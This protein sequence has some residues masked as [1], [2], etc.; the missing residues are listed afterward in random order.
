MNKENQ[1]TI[2]LIAIGIVLL[3]CIVGVI[4]VNFIFGNNN[5][6]DNDNSN[7]NG[8]NN[9]V[10]KSKGNKAIKK[11]YI[12]DLYGVV[13]LTNSGDLYGI[14]DFDVIDE[15]DKDKV[16]L[17]A[18]NVKDFGGESSIY[19]IDNSNTL[20]RSG[21]NYE[22][23]GSLDKFTKTFENVKSVDT[24]M[25]L[26]AGITT[27]NNEMYLHQGINVANSYCGA[28]NNQGV[29]YKK[30]ADN[31][32]TA[33]AAYYYNGYLDKNNNLYVSVDDG[34]THTKLLENIID[35]EERIF[36]D[37]YLTEDG[38]LYFVYGIWVD[39][40]KKIDYQEIEAEVESIELKE[41][42]KKKD[43]KFYYIFYSQYD[44][45]TTGMQDEIKLNI[46]DK[47][48]SIVYLKGGHDNG[49]AYIRKI[50]YINSEGK[51]VLYV[52]NEENFIYKKLDNNIDSIAEIYSFINQK[53]SY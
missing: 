52:S 2:I 47:A 48:E 42:I 33:I 29:G 51:Y 45:L 30:V 50:I 5:D 49:K 20:Y 46:D 19:Y 53:S 31:A 14:G 16:N 34:D 13:A 15:K 12:D 21:L 35:Y 36:G 37:Y 7:N 11:I 8:I 4:L 41:V 10:S 1:K 43:Q 23:G 18:T 40:Q 28:T 17:L 24:S 3:L 44:M 22:E 26:C 25:K 6:N 39:N 38:K 32:Q 27:N 9:I